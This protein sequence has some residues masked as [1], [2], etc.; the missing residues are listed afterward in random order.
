MFVMCSPRL[1]AVPQRK[2]S[3]RVRIPSQRRTQ[4]ALR[5]RRVFLMG[6]LKLRDV[7]A[8]LLDRADQYETASP[9]WIA[10]AD[11]A[12]NVMLGEV[13]AAKN[14]GEFDA[15][16][17]RRVDGMDRGAPVPV[18]PNLGAPYPCNAELYCETHEAYYDGRQKCPECAAPTTEEADR[19]E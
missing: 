12:R 9:C 10:L 15:G 16:L 11:A 19:D 6:A 4:R 2:P 5:L 7:A 18:Q 17:Y 3:L 14:N 1:R 13:A 8:Y